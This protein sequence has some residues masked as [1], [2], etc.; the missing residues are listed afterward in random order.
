[1]NP[2]NPTELKS[3]I[4]KHANFYRNERRGALTDGLR[5]YYDGHIRAM[6]ALWNR[7]KDMDEIT[8]RGLYKEI[9]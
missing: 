1:M 3:Y 7:L 6:R 2:I 4:V 5:H 9:S 8:S